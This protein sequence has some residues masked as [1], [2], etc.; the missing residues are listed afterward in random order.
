LAAGAGDGF[1]EQLGTV[2][3][4]LFQLQV[5]EVSGGRLASAITCQLS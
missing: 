3:T 5:D 2:A 4:Q 1:E